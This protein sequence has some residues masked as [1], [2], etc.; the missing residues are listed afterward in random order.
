MFVTEIPSP[1]RT[2]NRGQAGF[3]LS[4]MAAAALMS[5][6]PAT[7]A[8]LTATI[9]PG[10]GY[11]VT[12]DDSGNKVGSGYVQPS[13]ATPY[14]NSSSSGRSAAKGVGIGNE[15]Y[16]FAGPQYL[17]ARGFAIV[18]SGGYQLAPLGT[19][20]TGFGISSAQG[21][22]ES[23]LIAGN[24]HP[25]SADGTRDL[26]QRPVWYGPGDS[27]AHALP[28]PAGFTDTSGNGWGGTSNISLNGIIIGSAM[29][30]DGDTGI[31]QRALR[32]KS[33]DANPDV[34]QP[35][36]IT[37]STGNTNTQATAVNASGV[38]AGEGSIND[39]AG[40]WLAV[41]ALRWDMG[42]TKPDMLGSIGTSPD[43][44]FTCHSA[45]INRSGATVG[46]CDI[47]SADMSVS[48][49]PILWPAKS[50]TPIEL[51][52]VGRSR[53]GRSVAFAL[54]INDDSVIFG[55]GE[56][57]NAAGDFLGTR[58][59]RWASGQTQAQMLRPLSMDQAG[60]TYT[61]AYG[62]N[63]KGWV[64]GSANFKLNNIN[65]WRDP[66]YL[67][68]HAVVWDPKG[69]V[70]DLNSLLPPGAPWKLYS[71]MAISD[72]GLVTG[73]GW[74]LPE[75]G[76]LTEPYPRLFTMQLTNTGTVD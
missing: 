18:P 7:Q 14:P 73:L 74:Y 31:G 37:G 68:V 10:P 66:K 38:V 45:A 21:V 30:Y 16:F 20:N 29:L 36:T 19:S 12:L 15:Q 2:A 48:V 26:G 46:D 34:L 23:G 43:G 42:Q 17:G 44:R 53:D 3:C 56:Q 40:N 62:M 22:A 39:A 69:K 49:S 6:A 52:S 50:T 60:H 13:I 28:L 4:L 64:A 72:T 55:V 5:T 1:G 33:P 32:W 11:D 9:V 41:S 59:L 65:Y 47:Y 25:W 58:A 71:A 63:R 57:Y 54:G 61:F 27:T 35:P 75:A 51:Q 8:A 76:S 70:R 67:T 24:S